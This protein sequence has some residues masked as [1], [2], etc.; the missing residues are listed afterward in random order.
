MRVVPHVLVVP[1]LSL[2]IV[3]EHLFCGCLIIFTQGASDEQ[4][5]RPGLRKAIPARIE[6]EYKDMVISQLKEEIFELR[7]NQ[8]HYDKLSDMVNS[9]ELKARTFDREKVSQ[10]VTPGTHLG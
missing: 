4:R 1:V 10:A 7:K 6:S 8:V 9:L 5:R 3:L 2:A